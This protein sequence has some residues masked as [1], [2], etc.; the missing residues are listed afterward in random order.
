MSTL[1]AIKPETI[2]FLETLESSNKGKCRDW[3]YQA[4]ESMSPYRSKRDGDRKKVVYWVGIVDLDTVEKNKKSYPLLIAYNRIIMFDTFNDRY[5]DGAVKG[6]LNDFDPLYSYDLSLFLNEMVNSKFMNRYYH[7]FIKEEV[8]YSGLHQVWILANKNRKPGSAI[9]IKSQKP[10]PE[11]KVGEWIGYANWKLLDNE[12][13]E[14]FCIL[15]NEP[16]NW[17]K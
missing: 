5:D 6:G 9:G 16:Y 3:R 10:W 14:C 1:T 7:F 8:D 4:W 15:A 2:N 11:E 13:L 12:K 17:M